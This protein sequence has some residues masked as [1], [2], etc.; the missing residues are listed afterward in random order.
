MNITLSPEAEKVVNE[1]VQNGDYASASEVVEDALRALEAWKVRDYEEAVAGIR[2]GIEA[3]DAGRTTS[4]EDFEREMRA[5][6]GI[7]G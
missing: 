3:A 6:H 4:L 1:R 7:P 2:R 5:K